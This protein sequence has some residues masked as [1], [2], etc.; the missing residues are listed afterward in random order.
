MIGA[1]GMVSILA[2]IVVWV[3]LRSYSQLQDASSNTTLNSRTL[4]TI[5]V[6][7]EKN[8]KTDDRQDLELKDLREHDYRDYRRREK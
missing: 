6:L 2:A 8:D 3:F 5:A 1:S 4:S 7:L